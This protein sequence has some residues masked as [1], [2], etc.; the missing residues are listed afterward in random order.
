MRKLQADPAYQYGSILPIATNRETGETEL[1]MPDMVREGLSEL[2]SAVTLPRRVMEGQPYSEN[3]VTRMALATT[4]AGS[5]AKAPAGAIGMSIQRIV[6]K[7]GLDLSPSEVYDF[8]VPGW[9]RAGKDT[10]SVFRNPTERHVNRAL[11]DARYMRVLRDTETNDLYVWPGDEGLHD[12]IMKKLGLADE[13]TEN[14]GYILSSEDL[15][16]VMHY[17]VT[18]EGPL[19][20][21]L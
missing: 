6:K 18:G 5:P 2:L 19:R 17:I 8:K 11:K 21:V 13:T 9:N 20:F 15:D 1:G 16:N 14:L 3:D 4:L 12:D 10:M 7:H